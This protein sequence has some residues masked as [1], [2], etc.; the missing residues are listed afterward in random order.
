MSDAAVRRTPAHLWI[1]GG[2]SALWNCFGVYDY[3]MSVTHN[4]A[5]LA[6]YSAEQRAYF[7]AFPAAM[8]ACWALGVW[9][10]L[11]GSLLLLARSR[12]AV[13][14]F[15]VS[16]FGLAASTFYQYVIGSPP[17]GSEEGSMVLMMVAIWAIAIGLLAYALAMRKRGVLR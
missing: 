4:A 16:L 14:A 1:V 7:D 17:P 15:A 6:N 8:V 2:V 12:H 10:A 11:A 9:G 13:A 5:Y 3:L